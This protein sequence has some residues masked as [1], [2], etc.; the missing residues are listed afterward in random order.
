MV[1]GSTLLVARRGLTR[2]KKIKR[3]F[4]D[5][6]QKKETRRKGMHASQLAIRNL[7]DTTGKHFNTPCIF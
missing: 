2:K 5:F 4:V 6:K 7:N 1:P 3:R